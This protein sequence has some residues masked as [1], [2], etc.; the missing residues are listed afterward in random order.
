M[1]YYHCRHC[2]NEIGKLP[3]SR[4]AE[5]LSSMQ[6]IVGST[7]ESR[8]LLYGNDGRI[9][10]LSICDQCEQTLAENPHY[11]ALERWLQ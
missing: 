1:V 9:N 10:V 7:G 5:T 4:A 8:F 3:V 2:K 6:Q 11:Y